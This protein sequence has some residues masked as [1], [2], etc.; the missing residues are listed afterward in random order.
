MNTKQILSRI[1]FAAA[2]SAIEQ[3]KK[4]VE[5]FE[6]SEESIGACIACNLGNVVILSPPANTGANRKCLSC[7]TLFRK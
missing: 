1:A 3:V 2:K 5:A 4:E 7:N 6:L